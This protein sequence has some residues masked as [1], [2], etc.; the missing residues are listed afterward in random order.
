MADYLG[1]SW[2]PRES[3][4]ELVRQRAAS[5]PDGVAYYAEHGPLTWASYDQRAQA[6]AGQLAGLGLAPGDRVAVYLPD[7]PLLHV[8][9]LAC[10]RAGLV[11]VGVPARA[12]DRELDH[13][14]RRTGA[15]L[16]V[17]REAYRD[18]TARQIVSEAHGRGVPLDLHG[19]LDDTGTLAG[20]TWAAGLPEAITAQTTTVAGRELG[21]GDLWL[22]NST[23][24]TTGLPK[25]VEQVQHKWMYLVRVAER[26]AGL[27]ADDVFMS[28]VPSPFGFGLWSA[29]I[30][31][32][33]VGGPCVLRERYTP[34]DAL[35]DVARYRVSVLACVTT[36]FLMMLASPVLG[37]VDLSSL[38]V[39]Y[40]GGERIPPDKAR[41]WERR[42]GSVVLNFYG[43]NEIGPFSCTALTDGERRLDTVGRVVPGTEY[44]LYDELGQDITATGG[45][46]QPGG[47][48]PGVLGGYW[49]DDAANAELFAPDGFLLMPD[50]ITV[51][52]DGYVRIVGRKADLIIR[53]G[54]NISAASVEA[55]VSA[56]PDVDLVAAVAVPDP[57]FGER[58]CAVITM[59]APG[60]TLA[61]DQ[62]REFLAERGV[63]KEY[64]PEYL[65]VVDEMPQSSG[66]KI[67]KN[68]LRAALSARFAENRRT[69][70]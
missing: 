6:L 34:G 47:R 38:R 60:T 23:S 66:G 7:S 10:E 41:E 8:T 35:R 12:G 46:G 11:V 53:G 33:L 57:V 62:L 61:L 48:G 51:D 24:G 2:W 15:R 56:H 5:T 28:V 45:P 63:G 20:Y 68:E 17:T 39:L 70:S 64:F 59:R 21:P 19:E 42:T 9:Y 65:A 36:Q 69:E 44:R 37:E 18:R 54:K 3:L 31:P 55:E 25:C 1:Q 26:A 50:L 40:A 43:S 52:D 13:L 16:L 4:G 49:D 30:A 27:A 67:A 22:L 32:A 14:I 58:V 29:H